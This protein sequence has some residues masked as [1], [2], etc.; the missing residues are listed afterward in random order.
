MNTSTPVLKMGI[1]WIYGV[2]TVAI[3]SGCASAQPDAVEDDTPFLEA[4]TAEVQATVTSVNAQGTWVAD[5]L[6]PQAPQAS[7]QI[8]GRAT[9]SGPGG[10]TRRM[11][12]C[13][14][15][16]YLSGGGG[17]ACNTAADCGNAPASLPAGGFRYCTNPNGSGTKYC[18]F[19]PGP[20]TSFC[21]G[22]PANGNVP[23]APSTLYTPHNAYTAPSV[24]YA[25]FE[26]C[27]A[28]DPSVSSGETVYSNPDKPK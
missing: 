18:Y 27:A 22:T 7:G 8:W 23:I 16:K 5:A 4:D 9:F 28:T 11:G 15:H 3:A 17:T 14:L 13:L 6:S 20:P 12:V 24:S 2:V 10:A 19:R 25:C 26:G 1:A 21:A